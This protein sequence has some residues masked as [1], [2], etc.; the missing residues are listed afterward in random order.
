MKITLTDSELGLLS[1]ALIKCDILSSAGVLDKPWCD[2]HD[3]S[4]TSWVLLA[5][6]TG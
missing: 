5:Y 4:E 2:D 1:L 6:R 3:A